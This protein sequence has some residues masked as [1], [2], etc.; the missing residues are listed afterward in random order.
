MGFDGA[1]SAG[2]QRTSLWTNELLTDRP[3]LAIR[4]SGLKKTEHNRRDKSRRETSTPPFKHTPSEH[5]DKTHAR[6]LHS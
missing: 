2:L 6:P 5:H 4:F 3:Q 1:T